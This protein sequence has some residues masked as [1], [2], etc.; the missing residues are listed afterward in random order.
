MGARK[1][2]ADSLAYF[3]SAAKMMPWSITVEHS[4]IAGQKREDRFINV[5]SDDWEE[6]REH[7]TVRHLMKFHNFVIQDTIICD[8]KTVYNPE[9]KLKYARPKSGI[10][11]KDKTG[12]EVGC[13]FRVVSTQTALE[14]SETQ[15]GGKL[16]LKYVDGTKLPFP[17]S[18]E[19]ITT[20]LNR[21]TWI[22]M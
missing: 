19:L 10:K 13:R 1:V 11:T 18:V 12:F 9:I 15:N 21:Q 6:A 16:T 3:Q 2:K 17:S 20:Q 14:I 4:T 5:P 8:K 7:L 22:R